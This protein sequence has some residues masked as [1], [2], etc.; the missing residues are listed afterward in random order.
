[1]TG[2]KISA[3]GLLL[4]VSTLALPFRAGSVELLKMKL[5]DMVEQSDYILIA[6]VTRTY[7]EKPLKFAD[8][9]P[10]TLVKG[11]SP[12]TIMYRDG[13]SEHN[14][15]CCEPGASY[16]FFLQNT[17]SGIIVTVGGRDAAVKVTA[18]GQPN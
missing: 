9:E 1:M 16:L 13:I 11:T 7:G 4:A 18:Q 10:I 15:D 2:L 5:G 14:P 6:R 3:L 12:S 17:P 8:I